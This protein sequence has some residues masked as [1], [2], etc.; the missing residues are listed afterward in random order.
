MLP[1][2]FFLLSGVLI[3]VAGSVIWRYRERPAVRTALTVLG[4]DRTAEWAVVII[5]LATVGV[6][7]MIAQQQTDILNKQ[8]AIAES[9]TQLMK[10]QYLPVFELKL[11]AVPDPDSSNMMVERL[12]VIN[13]G[14]QPRDLSIYLMPFAAVNEFF[15]D[16]SN[17]TTLIPIIGYYT[18]P[19]SGPRG[20]NGNT[21]GEIGSW[22]GLVV[23]NYQI[24][25]GKPTWG[26]L[27]GLLRDFWSYVPES[28]KRISWNFPIIV[29]VDIRYRDV[30]SNDMHREIY[31][32]TQTGFG[33]L[34]DD[35][36]FA[37]MDRW[38]PYSPDFSGPYDFTDYIDVE[39]PTSGKEVF[40]IWR[41]RR[42][43]QGFPLSD[44]AGTPIP[45]D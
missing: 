40:D 42:E 6:A 13:T 44:Q 9:Q 19:S 39:R 28:K 4:A 24:V 29:Y 5:G 11:E 32:V 14:G 18:Y 35:Q 12:I 30:V 45:A 17:I 36:G 23:E 20:L 27:S 8:A 34:D 33:R 15:A 1:I 16:S 2:P 38:N 3:L 43:A 21:Q 25:G 41:K 31:Q 26:V 10:M 7:W 37:L 22:N